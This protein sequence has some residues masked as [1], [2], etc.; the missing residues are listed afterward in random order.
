AFLQDSALG[1]GTLAMA[2]LLRADG[3]LGTAAANPG[4]YDL[5]LRTGHFPGPAKSVILLM[6]SGGPSQVDLFDPKPELQK[7]HGQRHPGQVESFQPGSH[8]N[9]LMACA[10]KFRRHGQCGMDFSELLPHLG[11]VADDLC[12]VRSMY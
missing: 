6:Q 1:F 9:Q 10:Y 7:R 8:D 11:G 2:Y 3:L 4:G 5:R 12:M